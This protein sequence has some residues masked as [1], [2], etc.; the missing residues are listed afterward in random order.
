MSTHIK[1]M[2][3]ASSMAVIALILQG[4]VTAQFSTGPLSPGTTSE[5]S[6]VGTIS[7]NNPGSV[8]SSNNVYADFGALIGI[9]ASANTHYLYAQSFGFSIPTTAVITGIQVDIEHSTGG[10][11]VVGGGVSDNILRLLKGGGL[12]GNNLAGGYWPTSDGYLA[13]GGAGNLW[14]TS[15][16][17]AE[18]ND[19]S[20]GIAFSAKLSAGLASIFI[21]G[22][23]DHIRMTVFYDIPL[24]VELTHFDADMLQNGSVDVAWE[25]ASEINNDRFILEKSEDAQKWTTATIVQG[26]GNNNTPK[27]YTF[28]DAKPFNRGTYYRLTQYDYDGSSQ[29]FDPVYVPGN[30]QCT[31]NYSYNPMTRTITLA[32]PPG[33]QGNVYIYNCSGTEIYSQPY[34]ETDMVSISASGFRQ[35]VY[36]L[37]VCDQD[38]VSQV[39]K[40]MIY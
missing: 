27:K 38:H 31:L 34:M 25:T 16:T 19:P 30:K 26:A 29:S 4:P 37:L 3:L 36:T 15:W 35:G 18:I 28:T 32:D 17:A 22:Y 23:V 33:S 1:L 20:F 12:T 40:V 39:K 21:G 8:T 9:L 6:T 11:I 5:Q 7:W 14:G 2:P 10:L 24:P 13:Y